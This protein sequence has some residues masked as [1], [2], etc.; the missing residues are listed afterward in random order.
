MEVSQWLV[1]CEKHVSIPLKGGVHTPA[2]SDTV[3]CFTSYCCRTG[4]CDKRIRKMKLITVVD[5]RRKPT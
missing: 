1:E 2:P 4:D 5:G 3:R